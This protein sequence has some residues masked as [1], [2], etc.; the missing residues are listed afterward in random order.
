MADTT[1]RALRFVS[2]WDGA[3]RPGAA[4]TGGE[5]R[6]GSTR[7]SRSRVDVQGIENLLDSGPAIVVVNR[8]GAGWMRDLA[9]LVQA[10][11][12]HVGIDPARLPTGLLPPN[13]PIHALADAALSAGRIVIAYPEQGMPA[14]LARGV[15]R[16]RPFQ[17]TFVELAATHGAPILPI[18]SWNRRF[19]IGAPVRID[20]DPHQ[21][22]PAAY[23]AAAEEIRQLLQT[24]LDDGP[25]DRP[26]PR[27]SGSG[28]SGRAGDRGTIPEPPLA[29]A[30]GSAPLATEARV[31]IPDLQHRVRVLEAREQ[32]FRAMVVW[33][34]ALDTI[35]R[36]HDR[37]FAEHIADDLMSPDGTFDLE[38][39]GWGCWGP[40]KAEIVEH[41]M[42]FV[43]RFSWAYHTYP[44]GEIDVD[45]DR[46]TGRFHTT[47]EVVPLT[48]D[49]NFQFFFLTMTTDFVLVEGHWKVKLYKLSDLRTVSPVPSQMW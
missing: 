35:E 41:L 7:W 36:T 47:T 4:G 19:R 1:P 3:A 37:H 9:A 42:S 39:T 20:I 17:T 12:A 10:W 30:R 24:L 46:G 8:A 40:D 5:A 11:A 13:L 43:R 15:P 44:N 25:A 49:G 34:R 26:A 6:L 33:G 45:V 27:P 14:L 2:P 48:R 22:S 18:A 29:D 38:D 31:T 28:G 23:R 21:A 32:I 16:V